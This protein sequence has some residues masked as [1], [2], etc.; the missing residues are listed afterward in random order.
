MTTR[1]DMA[2]GEKLYHAK[3]LL[4]GEY[5]IIKDSMG[6]SIPYDFYKGALVLPEGE[7]DATARQSNE[8]IARFAQYLE[9]LHQDPTFEAHIDTGSLRRDVE[10]GL[11]FDSSIP[12]GYGVGSSGALVAAIYERYASPRKKPEE[13]T[14][15]DIVRLKGILGKMESFFHGHSSGLDPLICYM[16]L[17][18]LVRPHG[19]IDPVGIPASNAQGAGAIFLLDSGMQHA[20][21]KLIDIFFEK[22]KN[23]GFRKMLR[24][25]FGAL[26]DACIQAFIEGR[27]KSLLE[28]VRALS[29]VVLTHFSPMIPRSLRKIWLDGLQTDTYYLKLCGA[30][31][32]GFVLGF[33][34]DYRKAARM[35]RGYA[36]QPIYRF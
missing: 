1:Q 26:N 15:E 25:E 35:L 9:T 33:T 19:A 4:F 13:L 28:N 17:S 8:H 30:G 21:G 6:L 3:V 11:Y 36:T 20:T 27:K 24:E 12:L 31:G 10:A 32:G 34:D 16:N 22:M 23:E 7:P 2:L 5:G 18:I 29:Q 14:T